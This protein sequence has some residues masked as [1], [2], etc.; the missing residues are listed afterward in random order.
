MEGKGEQTEA[1]ELQTGERREKEEMNKE[2]QTAVLFQEVLT[3]H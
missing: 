1:A 2:H 3:S